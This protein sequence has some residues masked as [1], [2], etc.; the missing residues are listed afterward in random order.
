MGLVASVVTA[1]PSHAAGAGV[2]L[3]WALENENPNP[4]ELPRPGRP[5]FIRFFIVNA[6]P[7]LSTAGGL[8]DAGRTGPAEHPDA[9][10]PDA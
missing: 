5:R 9:E 10:Q 7:L 2:L 6:A 1:A 8:A 4:N 3:P